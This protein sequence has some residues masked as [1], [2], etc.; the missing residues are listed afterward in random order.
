MCGFVRSVDRGKHTVTCSFSDELLRL[1]LDG[2]VDGSGTLE[3]SYVDTDTQ[4]QVRALDQFRN[5][6]FLQG[7]SSE[8]R[9]AF[10]NLRRVLLGLR[11][12]PADTISTRCRF[13][14][15]RPSERRSAAG[16][17]AHQLQQSA[18][19]GPGAAGDRKDRHHRD[20]HRS[21]PSPVPRRTSCGRF[22]GER[23]GG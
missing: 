12:P 18:H 2:Q 4:R 13:S 17:P 10:R 15:H 20:C 19:A 5:V 6:S 16:R 21:V 8:D 7:K 3:C 1:F 11:Q 14:R 23:G 9:E 22:A